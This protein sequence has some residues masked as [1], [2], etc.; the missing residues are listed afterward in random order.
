MPAS[1]Y[2][3]GEHERRYDGVAAARFAVPGVL[4]GLHLGRVVAAFSH[5]DSRA[6]AVRD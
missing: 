2:E 1:L 3:T 6:D 5:A 4:I